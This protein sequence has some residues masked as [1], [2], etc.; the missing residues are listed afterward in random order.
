MALNTNRI[1]VVGLGSIG[2]RHAR[3]L[4]GRGDL[5]VEWCESSPEALEL[6]RRE[7]GEPSVLHPNFAAVLAS[8]PALVGISTPHALHAEQAIAALQAGWHVLCEKPLSDSLERARAM[9]AAAGRAK[10]IFTVGFQMHFHPAVRR[11]KA[12]VEGGE[13]GSIHHAHAH[14]GTYITLVNS[15]SRYQATLPGALLMDY[16]HQPDVFHFI[17]SERPA[18]VYARGGQGGGLPLQ[19]NPNFVA[20]VCDYKRPLISTIHL[21]YLQMPD[22]NQMEIIGDKGWLTLDLA[23]G[24][25]LV[26]RQSDSSTRRETFAS[27]RDVWYRDEH[28]AFLGAVAGTRRPESPAQDALVSMEV[29]GAALNS[30]ATGQR[31]PLGGA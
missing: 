21:N 24:D 1:V 10:T 28:E 27:E 18:G 15:R 19:S 22:R 6:A 13:L 23:K 8:P 4:K 12:L 14:V 25:L 9:V 26:G 3:L 31:V 16:A 17:L 7:L 29:I 11:V 2:R 5:Q 30:L 20:L